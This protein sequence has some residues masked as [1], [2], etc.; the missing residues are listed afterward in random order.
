MHWPELHQLFSSNVDELTSEER[1]MNVI[2]N[3]HLV[4]WFFTKWV[5]EFIKEWLYNSLDA[6]WH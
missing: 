5:E 4:D 1:R 3:P 6:E 2:N